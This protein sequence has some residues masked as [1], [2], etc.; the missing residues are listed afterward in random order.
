[1][2]LDASVASTLQIMEPKTWDRFLKGL[3]KYVANYT[4]ALRRS[5]LITLVSLFNAFIVVLMFP[6]YCELLDCKPNSVWI[7]ILFLLVVGLYGLIYLQV[8][9]KRQMSRAKRAKECFVPLF[10]DR[11][12]QERIY[13]EFR[14]E[15]HRYCDRCLHST[16]LWHWCWYVFPAVQLL[17]DSIIDPGDHE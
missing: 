1:M 7:V 16:G 3:E 17:S 8:L 12:Q 4:I 13:L 6:S 10:S 5:R 14:K 9:S 15:F 11:F 2:P